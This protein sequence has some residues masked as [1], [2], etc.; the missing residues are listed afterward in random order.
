M[1]QSGLLLVARDA[2]IRSACRGWLPPSGAPFKKTITDPFTRKPVIVVSAPVPDAVNASLE[3]DSVADV[4]KALRKVE[5]LCI[6]LKIKPKMSFSLSAEPFL[7]GFDRNFEEMMGVPKISKIAV[8][9]ENDAA[10]YV[11]DK[12]GEYCDPA[13]RRAER[14]SMFLITYA[15]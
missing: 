5:P 12:L 6:E 7:F 13:K 4:S 2:S 8:D 14:L 11:G 3:C 10:K 15:F 1:S 9:A